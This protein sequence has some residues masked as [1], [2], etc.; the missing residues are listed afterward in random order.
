[1]IKQ[2]TMSFLYP[3]AGLLL[4]GLACGL[5]GCRENGKAARHGA[6][7]PPVLIGQVSRKTVPLTLDAIGVV[8]PSRTVSV[9]SQVTGTLLKIDFA[10]GHDVKAGDLLFEIDPRPFQNALRSA[11]ADLQKAHVQLENARSQSKRY[12]SLNAESAISKEQFQ[13]I[14]DNE[15]TAAAQVHF[16]EA[17]VASARLEL[18]YCSIRAPISGRT[19]VYGVH[20]GDLVSSGSATPLVVIN[21]LSP[22]YVTFGVPQQNLGEL[23]RYRSAGPVHVD[24]TPPGDDP[25]PE[26]G[27]LIF[28]DNNVDSTTGTLKLKAAFPNGSHRL[29]PGQFVTVRIMLATPDELV[30]PSNAVQNDQDG[31]HVFVVRADRTAEFRP[32]VVTRTYGADTVVSRGLAAGETVITDGQL[33]V[34]SGK[35]VQI[36]PA[37]VADNAAAPASLTPR[38]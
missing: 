33:R 32:I 20:E 21:Q 30:V 38:D 22:T 4:L 27:E 37:A 9:R 1:M 19:G 5:A 7:A 24:A 6:S 18:D 34:I 8:E 12:R 36:K 2:L 28:I 11:E 17:A 13:T 3:S 26:T 14:E 15:R 10:E 23:R 29:W 35:P 25:K 16:G 31:Q